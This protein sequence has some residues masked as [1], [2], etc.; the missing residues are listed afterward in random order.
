[1]KVSDLK[2]QYPELFWGESDDG[3]FIGFSCGLGWYAPIATLMSKLEARRLNGER[4]RPLKIVQLKQKFG[5]LR[6]YYDGGDEKDRQ[7]IK[8]C[9][10]LADTMCDI[11]SAPGEKRGPGWIRTRCDKHVDQR[12]LYVEPEAAIRKELL[13]IFEGDEAQVDHWLRTPQTTFDDRPAIE[14]MQDLDGA[15]RVRDFLI[16]VSRAGPW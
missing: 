9:M 2:R 16:A 1:M 5:E 13:A 8:M 6:I 15:L 12:P 4:E 14:V 7:L 11:C 10:A 3:H